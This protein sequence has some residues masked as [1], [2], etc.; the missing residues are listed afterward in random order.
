MELATAKGLLD[1]VRSRK[2][3][4]AEALARHTNREAELVAMVAEKA[5]EVRAILEEVDGDA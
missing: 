5:A 3:A 4:T 2:A 1:T